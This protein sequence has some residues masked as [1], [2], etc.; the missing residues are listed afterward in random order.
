MAFVEE[1]RIGNWFIR[2]DTWK[3]QVVAR[4]LALLTPLMP[5][6]QQRY[7]R[8]LDV[9]C[10]FGLSFAQ[11]AEKF[12]PDLIVAVDADPGL[13]TRAGN[14]AAQ[15]ACKVELHSA[16]AAK[17]PFANES[18]DLIFCHQTFHHIVE[19]EAAMAEF[20]RVLKPGGVLL[21]AESTKRYIHS[22]I[23]RLFFRHPMDV[24]RTAEEY[25]AMIRKAGFDLPAER[26]NLPYLWWSRADLGLFEAL[27][28]KSSA[29]REETLVN[30]VGIKPDFALP[31]PR[32]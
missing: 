24:Q 3:T 21:F 20:Q 7:P 12:K 15:C 13:M 2:S 8:I 22:W 1:T 10:G 19:Q 25:I 32:G 4:A 27:G 11:L 23:I 16:D 31:T 28:F 5:S 17:M 6:N 14:A 29:Q 30:A 9:G 26:I 18:F